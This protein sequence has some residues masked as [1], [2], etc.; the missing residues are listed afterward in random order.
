MFL[1]D[2]EKS[3]M[4]F[5]CIRNL[6]SC[7]VYKNKIRLIIITARSPLVGH[8]NSSL[9]GLTTVRAFNAEQK[10][11]DEFDKHQDLYSSASI[12][13][14]LSTLGFTFYMD[15]MSALFSIVVIGRFLFFHHGKLYESLL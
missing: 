13:M 6:N 10:L 15:F 8:I 12:M 4:Q 9:E 1:K 11:R 5:V 2:I 7:F 14:R 3:C